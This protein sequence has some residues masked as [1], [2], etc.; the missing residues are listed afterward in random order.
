MRKTIK[1]LLTNFHN[2]IGAVMKGLI[3]RRAA[4]DELFLK[5]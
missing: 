1:G 4:E 5:K 2:G 3:R